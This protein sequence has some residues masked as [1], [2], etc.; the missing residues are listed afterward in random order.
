MNILEGAEVISP[1]RKKASK[2]HMV[3]GMEPLV[4]LVINAV[5]KSR[6]SKRI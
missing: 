5:I 4:W 6:A 3:G 1:K 2:S